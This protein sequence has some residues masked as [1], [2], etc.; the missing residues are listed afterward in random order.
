MAK[1]ERKRRHLFRFE[2]A[3]IVSGDYNEPTESYSNPDIRFERWGTYETRIPTE[4]V[5]ANRVHGA[6]GYDL[7]FRYDEQLAGTTADYRVT[8]LTDRNRVLELRGPAADPD[9]KQQKIKF[10]AVEETD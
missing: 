6:L 9:G 5:Q 1:C 3:K 8:I 10:V 7:E 4:F 2:K